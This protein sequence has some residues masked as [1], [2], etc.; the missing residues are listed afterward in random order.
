MPSFFAPLFFAVI[1]TIWSAFS[2]RR[3]AARGPAPLADH[4]EKEHDRLSGDRW[5]AHVMRMGLLLLLLIGVPIGLLLAAFL[6]AQPATR[7][8]AFLAFV[9]MTALWTVPGA[10]VIR[11]FT[12]R[13]YRR[14]SRSA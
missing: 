4:V 12:L 10:F 1:M 5:L 8:I 11:W 14:W 7:A 9:G 2:L 6:P 3:M 13:S